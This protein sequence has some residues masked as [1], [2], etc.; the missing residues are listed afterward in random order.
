MANINFWLRCQGDRMCPDTAI[1]FDNE[2]RAAVEIAL[3]GGIPDNSWWQA[4]LPVDKGGLGMRQ[5][6]QTGA[7]A[8]L[9]S[10]AAS[11][12]M[13][14]DLCMRMQHKGLGKA[15]DF[16]AQFDKRTIE[17]LDAQAGVW[18]DDLSNDIRL[19]LQ[20]GE[21]RA[22]EVW[23][24]DIYGDEV[25]QDLAEEDPEG[26]DVA[27]RSA[28]R[29]MG[30]RGAGVVLDAGREDP[31]HP[32][33]RRP[34]PKLQRELMGLI[35]AWRV[36]GLLNELDDKTPG[37]GFDVK[38]VVDL[39]DE[40]TDCNWMWSVSQVH[41]GSLPNQTE[42]GEAI[43]VRLGCGGPRDCTVCEVCQAAVVDGRGE[44]ASKCCIGEATRGHNRCA[45]EIF[46]YVK[47]IDPE[48]NSE[49]R[50]VVPSQKRLRPADILTT[51][52]CSRLTAADLGITSPAVA[53]SAELAKEAMVSRKFKE[54]TGIQLELSRQGIQYTP[55]VA[56]HFGSLH[57]TFDL[58]IR[59]IARAVARRRGYAVKAV[60]SQIRARVGASL[61]R[62]AARMSLACF[63]NHKEGEEVV[64]PIDD[65]FEELDRTPGDPNQGTPT[66]FNASGWRRKG[67]TAGGDQSRRNATWK[68]PG[69]KAPRPAWDPG[70][71]RG[72]G[73]KH[74][75]RHPNTSQGDWGA[76]DNG[77]GRFQ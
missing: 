53:D 24:R 46:H 26:D 67:K 20:Q 51:A 40:T 73:S 63:G 31:E 69:P 42:F 75:W 32:E 49:P 18:G 70:P 66:Q 8:F 12:A 64:L 16:M 7:A 23:R 14:D 74:R 37:G 68:A 59:N 2:L 65:G 36:R 60:E 39:G 55:M 72:W 34:G 50:E 76:P 58:W 29:H 54:R 45:E 3:G 43:R 44:H 22:Y 10:R 5:A 21:D 15:D 25:P 57:G 4:E 35:D 19:A 6:A 27:D 52:A 1:A 9:A 48:A 11:R 13:V 28:I 71:T 30:T 77:A 41:K 56:S 62:R 33:T 47:Q 61:A 38:R 17:C